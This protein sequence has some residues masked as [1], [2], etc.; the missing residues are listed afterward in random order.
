MTQPQAS[1]TRQGKLSLRTKARLTA[2]VA[3][4][5]LAMTLFAGPLFTGGTASGH[6][7][8]VVRADG[9]GD[10]VTTDEWNSTGS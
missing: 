3:M 7:A 9:P 6:T 2:S 1:T 4:T 5:A 10:G 8:S